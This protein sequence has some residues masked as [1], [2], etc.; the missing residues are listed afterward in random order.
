MPQPSAWFCY[1][2]QC[3][4]GTLY[5]GITNGLDKRIAAHNSGKASKYTRGRLPVAL[6]YSEPHPDRAAASRREVEIKR[7]PRAGKLALVAQ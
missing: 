7:L 1:L 2:L 4:D 3:A 6:L 5:T